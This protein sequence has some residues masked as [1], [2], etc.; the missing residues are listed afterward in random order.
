MNYAPINSVYD[1][2]PLDDQM[3]EM[4]EMDEIDPVDSIDSIDSIYPNYDN[5]YN[6][7]G[8]IFNQNYSKKWPKLPTKINTLNLMLISGGFSLFILICL[9]IF[10]FAFSKKQTRSYTEILNRPYTEIINE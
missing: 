5:K 1:N 10:Y 7:P 9:S 8:Y 4:D 3:D 2:E 6:K